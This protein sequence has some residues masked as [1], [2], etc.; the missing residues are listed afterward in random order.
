MAWLLAAQLPNAANAADTPEPV[1][2]ARPKAD[3]L[4]PARAQLAQQRYAAAVAELRK[5][6]GSNNA[7][8][9]NLMG[10][11]LRKSTPPDLDG[12]QRH[13]DTA[14]RL[15][16]QH[17]GALEYSG[18]LALMKGDLATAEARLAT[19]SRLCSS[20]CEALD[21]LKQAIAKYKAAGGKR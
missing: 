14:L 8:W 16:P 12:A 6:D 19:L 7:D 21:D 5:V 3:A 18:E 10:Y 2:A 4:A 13:Y 11:A 15:N 20:P 9:N 17:Q 1:P